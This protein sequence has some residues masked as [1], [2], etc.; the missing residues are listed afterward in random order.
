MCLF[1]FWLPLFLSLS[2]SLSLPLFLS[3]SSIFKHYRV[4]RKH[5]GGF[6]IDVDDPVS[7]KTS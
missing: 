4:T 7:V 1:V 2:L 5:E 3:I 6:N